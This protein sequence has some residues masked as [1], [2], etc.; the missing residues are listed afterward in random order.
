MRVTKMWRT[1]VTMT[2]GRIRFRGKTYRVQGRR[3]INR[4]EYLIVEQLGNQNR[5]KSLAFLPDA[6]PGGDLRMIHVVQRTPESVQLLKVLKRLVDDSRNFPKIVEHEIRGTRITLVSTWI[7]GENLA[8][9][10]DRARHAPSLW[11]T[12]YMAFRLFRGLAHALHQVHH[13]QNIV[14]GDIKPANL[15]LAPAPLRLVVIDF[16]S[17][18]TVEQTVNRLPG[19]GRT[20]LFASPEQLRDERRL[21]FRSDQFSC[22]V[23]AYLM[24][25]G[26]LPYDGIGGKAGLDSFRDRY[27]S[28]LVPP[29]ATCRSRAAMPAEF[30]RHV[31]AV[32][33]RGLALDAENRFANPR[34]WI[35]RLNEIDARLK[36]TSEPGLLE[37]VARR[38][39]SWFGSARRS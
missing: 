32:I 1:I 31:D 19:D 5:E 30:W 10:L 28:L 2:G 15:I 25:T 38:L 13:K 21:D 3:W 33:V 22:S 36:L 20:E 29:S 14:H 27:E 11:P 8:Y 24:L 17:A 9:R 16:G 12:P 7:H 37:R 35:D 4:R 39:F 6:C 23:V 34:E 26:A 18:W